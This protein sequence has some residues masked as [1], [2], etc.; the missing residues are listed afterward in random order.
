MLRGFATIS[1]MGPTDVLQELSTKPDRVWQVDVRNV[2]GTE[3]GH[4]GT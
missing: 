1:Y 3:V 2:A 4:T